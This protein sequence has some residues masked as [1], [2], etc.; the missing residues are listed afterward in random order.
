MDKNWFDTLTDD[1]KCLMKALSGLITDASDIMDVMT[2]GMNK[3]TNKYVRL[4]YV[5]TL[6]EALGIEEG[7]HCTVGNIDR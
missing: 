6:I 2:K 7:N 4:G 3:E 5:Q 1:Q